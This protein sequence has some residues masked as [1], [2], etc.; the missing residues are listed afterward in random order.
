MFTPW[1]TR[2]LTPATQPGFGDLWQRPKC[3]AGYFFFGQVLLCLPDG[4]KELSKQK[5]GVPGV[6]ASFP[7]VAAE[8]HSARK[9]VARFFLS[10][11][12]YGSW[13]ERKDSLASRGLS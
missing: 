13:R 10:I 3:S 8:W 11:Q 1:Q 7:E 5:N 9:H 6:N 12:S 4:R 2:Y